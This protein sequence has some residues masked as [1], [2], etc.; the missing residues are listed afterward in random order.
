MDSSAQVW[1]DH[2]SDELTFWHAKLSEESESGRSLRGRATVRPLEQWIRKEIRNP[3][4]IV[5]ILDVGAGPL[6]SIGTQWPGHELEV[7][8]LDPLADSYNRLLEEVGI[9]A[10]VPTIYG[11]G[12]DLV[13]RFGV[14]R[15]DF[16]VSTNA[17]D[18]CA[19]PARVVQQ[20]FEVAR[21]GGVVF[22]NHFIDVAD[23]EDHTGLHQWNLRPEGNDMVIEGHGRT[24]L[25][26]ELVPEC[27]LE[28][29]DRGTD[30][31]ARLVKLDRP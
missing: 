29:L 3:G 17:L 25:A 30:F 7:V 19:E 8:P 11:T 22:L 12:E 27:A 21:P 16:V 5:R 24:Y 4:A 20:M 15:F 14:D 26:S 2:L 23:H 6:T 10:P 1:S 18:H 9:A 31:V 28:V 13:E